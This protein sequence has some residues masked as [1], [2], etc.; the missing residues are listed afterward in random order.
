[1]K[2][3]ER[4]Q[5]TIP[6]KL[7]EQY[8]FHPNTEVEFRPGLDGALEIRRKPA[9]VREGLHSMYGSARLPA[10]TDELMRLLRG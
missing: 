4:G 5:V 3:G 6:R 7:R 1:M 8:G 10:G 9:A 2:I